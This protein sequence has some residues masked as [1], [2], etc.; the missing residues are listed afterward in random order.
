MKLNHFKIGHRLAC[1]AG[2]LL[3]A[4]LL[5]GARGL[6]VN[7]QALANN[8][9][10]MAQELLIAES[11]DTARNAQVH[12]KIQVQE[13]KDTLLRGA[14]GAEM[15]N[16]YKTAF[17]QESQQT[18]GLLLHLLRIQKQLGMSTTA[19]EKTREI[20]AG[21]EANYLH[22]LEN[23]DQHDIGSA[24]RV[25]KLVKG[26]DRA[27]TQM[28]DDL[29][30]ATLQRSQEMHQTIAA[31]NLQNYQHTRM[32]LLLGMGSV[33]LLGTLVTCWLIQS[34]TRPLHQSIAVAKR[35]ASGDLTGKISVKGADETA[36][37]MRA[38]QEMNDNLTRIV[39]GVRAGTDAIAQTTEQVADGSRELSARNEAQAS[40]LEQTAASM[41]ELTSVVKNNASNAQH[42]S[43]IAQ[44]TRDRAAEG[45]VVVD[46]VVVAMDEIHQF[47]REINEIVTVIDG[48][49]FQTNILAL[50]AA[51][52]AARAGNEG[53]G[54][55]VVAA[56]VRALAQ[57]SGVAARDIRA[58][59]DRSVGL[60]S[61]G[62]TL[63]KGA[64]S[65]MQEIVCSVK[66]LCELMENISAASTEQSS[67]IE[68]VNLAVTHLDAAT[69]QNATLSQQSSHAARDLNQQV[70]VLVNNVSVFRLEAETREETSPLPQPA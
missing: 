35:V 64:G 2:L 68:Q 39:S 49:A 27:P 33:L 7:Q 28:I 42:A 34:I 10:I 23:Y 40:A 11:I 25:D 36:Q 29:V 1:L 56:E 8:Q 44:H 52:E 63:V 51:V 43:D 50:N 5:T 69:Q 67:G 46:K 21:L 57:R 3:F 20:H 55:A 4:T 9:A 6:L 22:A 19:V 16:K 61:H 58:L 38:L 31:S 37:L 70:N 45:G 32:T 53:R 26:I 17:L 59:T 13:W 54:F 48:I 47:S 62:N 41:E 66:Q 65:S 12:F 18:Q 14:Q 15:F 24:Q 30:T 60:I